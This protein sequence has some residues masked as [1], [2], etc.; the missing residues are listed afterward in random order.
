MA[1]IA[2]LGTGVMGREMASRLIGAGHEVCVYNR[3][4]A[5]TEPLVA[6]GARSAPTPA[7]A[8]CG[9]EF[10][11]SMVGDDAASRRI[12]LGADGVLAGHPG[13][14]AIAVESSTLSRDWILELDRAVTEAGL[15]FI[16]CPVT[17]GPDGAHEGRLI[18]LVGAAPET[19]DR[20]RDVF[21]A[22]SDRIIHFG[23]VG[24]GAAYKVMVNLMGAAQAAALAEGMLAAE[25]AGLDMEKVGEALNCGAVASPMV[26]GLMERMVSGNHDGVYF[27]AR[28]RHKDA[29]YG[30]RLGDEVGQPMEV[31]RTAA[32]AFQKALDLGLGEK[33]ESV[34]I[35]ALRQDD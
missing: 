16:D 6:A 21:S 17:G 10:I 25:R 5:K 1:N 29:V 18:L 8:A 35:E 19:L 26:K 14:G 12:W 23:G 11:I 2:F 24:Q 13:A 15:G 32:E 31:C 22:Y 3:T 7:E 33:N 9:A 20:A 28:W 27:S 4:A 34:I 30:L